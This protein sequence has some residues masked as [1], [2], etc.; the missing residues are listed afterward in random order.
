M[1]GPFETVELEPSRAA[2]F[3]V[4]RFDESGTL[5]SEKTQAH[6]ISALQ[7]GDY[8]D[9]YVFSHGWNNT[10]DDAL[11]LYRGYWRGYLD[12]RRS[13]SLNNAAYKPLF[14]GIHWP[15]I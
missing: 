11:N 1:V 12:L 4:L 8:S 2:P 6:L 5:K 14:V 9:I 3:Y 10:F 7:L 15:S 13:R